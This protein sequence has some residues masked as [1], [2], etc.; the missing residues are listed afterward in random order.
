MV[1]VLSR[2]VRFGSFDALVAGFSRIHR[3]LSNGKSALAAVGGPGPCDADNVLV[4]A[5]NR[6]LHILLFGQCGEIPAANGHVEA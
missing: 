6:L 2:L 1:M 5:F 4:A 3:A